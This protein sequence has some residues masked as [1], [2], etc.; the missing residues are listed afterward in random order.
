MKE[1]DEE[2]DDGVTVFN[3]SVMLWKSLMRAY[4]G[5]YETNV[6]SRFEE[7]EGGGLTGSQAVWGC[8]SCR[9]SGALRCYYWTVVTPTVI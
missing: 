6:F 5:N 2:V 9:V 1:R 8:E 7:G 4:L 3:L